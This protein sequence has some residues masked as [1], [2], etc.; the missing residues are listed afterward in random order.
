M[1]AFEAGKGLG[2]R[3]LGALAQLLVFGLF[4]A[5][6]LSFLGRFSWV[7]ELFA[8][9]RPHLAAA[10]ALALIVCALARSR[11]AIAV[12]LVL[13]FI[14]AAPLVLYRASVP[15]TSDK[16]G[17]TLNVLELNLHGEGADSEK[18]RRLLRRENPDVVLLTELPR[19]IDHRLG[20][21]TVRYPYKLF[22]DRDGIFEV[23]VLSRWRPT[24]WHVDRS[25]ADWLPLLVA[26]LCADAPS[27]GLS[28][29]VRMV[30]LH[31]PPPF[32]VNADRRDRM[33]AMAA[34]FATKAGGRPGLVMGDLNVTP[35]APT[36]TALVKDAGLVDTGRM[37]GLS[38]TW[39]SRSPFLGLF[40]DHILVSRNVSVL[41][42]K[43]WEGVGSDHFP[44][45]AHLRLGA[46]EE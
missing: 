16:A 25:V 35:W 27:D 29:C 15:E 5:T 12:S 32:G 38:A 36:F 14:N 23:L 31:P 40:I 9:F 20:E 26:D 43:V 39:I 44:V 21:A 30:G 7:F 3:M 45:V 33:L 37:R 42:S 22:S 17:V 46:R 24:S 4:F 11:T 6:A 41:E 10:S 13:V 28:S 8:H 19:D 34:R 18:F 1:T 2:A